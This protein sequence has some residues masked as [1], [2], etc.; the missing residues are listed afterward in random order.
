METKRH[1]RGTAST[2]RF[3]VNQS[4]SGNSMVTR[5]CNED[6][7]TQVVVAGE[8][9]LAEWADIFALL[10]ISYDLGIGVEEVVDGP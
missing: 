1:F 3:T 5:I 6:A 9:E 10:A 8:W 2:N 7:N 4:G